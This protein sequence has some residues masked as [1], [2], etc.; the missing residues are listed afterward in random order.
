M[1]DIM[2]QNTSLMGESTNDSEN[3]NI[4]E[5]ERI[6]LLQWNICGVT[7]KYAIL[8]SQIIPGQHDIILLQET[9][10]R[11]NKPFSLKG[12]TVYRTHYDER[13][14]GLLTLVKDTIP[15]KQINNIDCGDETETLS[16]EITLLNTSLFVHNIYKRP[17]CNLEGDILF[18]C[19][20]S[21][22]TIFAGDFNAHH[23]C[24][25]SPRVSNPT[26]THLNQLM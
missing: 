1:T 9:L 24:L 15:S 18:N 22:S 10:L 14:R 7:R 23:P 12:Y 13:G 11:E 19:A 26:G 20:S 3:G 2:T 16:I 5:N 21:E 25:N 4:I 8:Q 6:K 17:N